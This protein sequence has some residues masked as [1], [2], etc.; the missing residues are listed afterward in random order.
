MSYSTAKMSLPSSY[1]S[2]SAE[3]NSSCSHSQLPPCQACSISPD[4]DTGIKS[5]SRDYLSLLLVLLIQLSS[6]LIKHKFHDFAPL[7]KL[8]CCSAD[9]MSFGLFVF[10][11]SSSHPSSRYL[12]LFFP[13][14]ATSLS[15][16]SFSP[17]TEILKYY[18]VL[19]SSIAITNEIFKT[20]QVL[21]R[22]IFQIPVLSL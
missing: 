10:R 9:Q 18:L 1:P 14:P 8:I 22:I 20:L 21:R 12:S 7:L 15:I 11:F 5:I 4:S 16:F 2:L 6:F 3:L 19:F 17:P 13:G